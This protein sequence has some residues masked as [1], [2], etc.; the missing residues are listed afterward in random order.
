[1][2][3]NDIC[4]D[5]VKV[6]EGAWV[7]NIPELEGLRV[8]VRGINNK[9]WRRMRARLIEA[10]PRKRKIGGL[11]PADQDRIT[12]VLLRETSLLDWG[13]LDGDDGKPVPYSK[14]VAGKYLSDPKY[15]KFREGVLWAATNVGEQIDESIGTDAKN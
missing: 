4:V 13:G 1:M 6:E 5:P 3:L 11:D 8:K 14:D 9:D 2:K 10:V 15:E 12:A 7:D